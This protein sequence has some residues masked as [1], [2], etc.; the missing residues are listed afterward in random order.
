[1]P[2]NSKVITELDT[3]MPRCCSIFIQS[4]RVWRRSRRALTIPASWIAPPNSSSFSV[5]VVLP[6]SG[7][8]MMAKVRRGNG[9]IWSATAP[10]VVS[11]SSSTRCEAISSMPLL[12]DGSRVSPRVSVWLKAQAAANRWDRRRTQLA[13]KPDQ[14]RTRT[15]CIE[16]ASSQ[17]KVPLVSMLAHANTTQPGASARRGSR[18][19]VRISGRMMR[20]R[21]SASTR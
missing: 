1:M 6:A 3:E 13:S 19:S 12:F 9:A 4:E 20:R 11:R 7:C 14:T 2:S 16:G 15:A 8:E 5:S 17:P 21:S 18:K 10:A